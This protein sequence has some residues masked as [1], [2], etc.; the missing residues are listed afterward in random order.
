ML[1][2]RRS[3]LVVCATTVAV[4]TLPLPTTAQPADDFRPRT[5]TVAATGDIMVDSPIKEAGATYA[6][7]G[8]TYDFAP[9]FAPITP[10]L[11]RADLAICHMEFPIGAR[12]EFAGPYGREGSS[13]YRW[14]AP[15]E[16]AGSVARAGYNRCSTASNHAND[17]GADGLDSTLAAL[18]DAG[19]SHVGT[20]RTEAEAA[21]STF[22][23]NGVRVAHLAYTKTN[24]VN[25]PAAFRLNQ[26]SEDAI[27]ADVEEARR[28]GAEIV[29]VSLHLGREMLSEPLGRDRIFVDN[30]L[31]RTHIDLVLHH[32]PHVIQPMEVVKGTPVY[33][34]LGNEM[35]G[36]GRPELGRYGDLRTLDGLLAMVRFVERP[37][38]T[39]QATP[40]AILLCEDVQSRV[41]YPAVATLVAGAPN[42]GVERRIQQCI[43]RSAELLGG[44]A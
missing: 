2:A 10:L 43:D 31:A 30:L 4:A 44:T 23:V 36:M 14:L 7:P 9:L 24:N 20:A 5:L 21:V 22:E 8:E 18:D 32:G 37:D 6:D 15:Y 26:S 33:W 11:Q 13:G 40:K 35:S 25:A 27:V 12:G 41:I 28:Q 39:F 3:L 19:L 42:E 17:L 29:V 16:I 34:S 1:R 38:G